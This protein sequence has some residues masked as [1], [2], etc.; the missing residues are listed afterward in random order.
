MT[1]TGE[2]ARPQLDGSEESIMDWVRTHSR[3][4]GVGAIVVAVAVVGTWLVSSSN[5][6]K[7]GSAGRAL[8]EAQRS[9][10]SGN[11][12]LAAAD[13]SKLVQRYGSTSA[14]VQARLML[15]Q[16]YF[17][18]GKVG[19]GLKLLD[20]AG[21]AGAQQS[22][23]HGL[24]AGGLEQSGKPLEAAAEYLKAASSTVLPSEGESYRSDAARAY[25]AAGKKDEALKLWKA[26]SDDA[27]SALNSE[28]KLRVGELSAVPSTKK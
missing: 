11:L 17:Q 25:A 27:S 6:K 1:K 9:V 24:R 13:L 3:Q 21:S 18:Q 4:V 28:A 22:S 26:M 8:S 23:L 20:D 12:P 16:V 19:D 2:A 5:A 10:A 15:A 14:G 7:A